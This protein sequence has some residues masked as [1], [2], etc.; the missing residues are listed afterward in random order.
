[1]NSELISSRNRGMGLLL[2][3]LALWLLASYTWQGN[4]SPANALE[5]TGFVVDLNLASESELSLLP[6]VGPKT[7]KDIVAYRNRVGKFQS[8]D[9]LKQIPGI[10]QARF[11]AMS[12]YVTIG[13]PD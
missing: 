3:C 1:M 12:P 10:K 8:V 11:D 6:G 9:Q 5:Q 13:L 4:E 7:A 2:V